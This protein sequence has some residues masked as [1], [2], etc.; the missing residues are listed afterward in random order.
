MLAFLAEL[1]PR[2]S[3]PLHVAAFA[4]M[5][6]SI[7]VWSRCMLSFTY[8]LETDEDGGAPDLVIREN[9]AKSSRILS[10]VSIGGGRLIRS[11]KF[12]Q[13]GASVYDHRSSI[14]IKDHWVFEVAE[15]EGTAYIRFTPDE[16]MLGMIRLAGC[17]VIE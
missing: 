14:F 2:V 11:D 5:L 4:L 12:K 6:A 8:S 17:E 9:K 7:L 16:K 1:L 13:D 15:R 10:R 3:S